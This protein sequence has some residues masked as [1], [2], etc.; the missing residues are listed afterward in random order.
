MNTDKAMHYLMNVQIRLELIIAALV[1]IGLGYVH[2]HFAVRVA[3]SY[4]DNYRGK[5][6]AEKLQ[7]T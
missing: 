4:T 2:I 7:P 1:I 6:L 3:E 5:W